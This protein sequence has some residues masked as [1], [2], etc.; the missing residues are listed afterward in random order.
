MNP[1]H[2]IL[3]ASIFLAGLAF[4]LS[5]CYTDGYVSD[6]IYYGPQRGGP[7]FHDDPWMDGDRWY[8]GRPAGGG[9]VGIYLYPPRHRRWPN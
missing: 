4:G 8:G 6:S 5:S 7:W 9:E 2:K 1:I 3:L